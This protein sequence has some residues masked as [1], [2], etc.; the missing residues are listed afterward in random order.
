MD[1]AEWT[2]SVTAAVAAVPV[3][4][5]A[6]S[7]QAAAQRRAREQARC[8]HL[9]HLPPGSR[10]VDLGRHGMVIEVGGR[11]DGAKR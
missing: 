4:V 8:D 3:V 2:A 7:R 9:R 5:R 11:D 6:W 1:A 10:V